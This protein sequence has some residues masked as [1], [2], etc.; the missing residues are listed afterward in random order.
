MAAVS[1]ADSLRWLLC[2]GWGEKTTG[3]VRAELVRPNDAAS[4]VLRDLSGI[5][6]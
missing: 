2:Q 3:S 5:L 6:L 4:S 1:H